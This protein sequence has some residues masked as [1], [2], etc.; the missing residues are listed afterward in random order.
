MSGQILDFATGVVTEDDTPVEQ[1]SAEVL[2]AAER[3]RM[4]VFRLAFTLAL[5]A[6]PAPAPYEGTMLAVLDAVVAQADPY[7]DLPIW[8][9]N[10]TE[11]IRTHP[12]MDAFAAEFGLDA[13][14]VDNLFRLA[15]ALERGEDPTP[16]LP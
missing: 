6:L 1:P 11:M 5:R 10:V 9:T 8:W 13:E 12:N 7:S 3:A 4:R 14:T 16:F 2:L 15:I